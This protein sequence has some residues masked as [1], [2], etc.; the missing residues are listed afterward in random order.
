MKT[1]KIMAAPVLIICASVALSGCGGEDK[2]AKAKP[3]SSPSASATVNDG[4]DSQWATPKQTPSPQTGSESAGPPVTSVPSKGSFGNNPQAPDEDPAP[5]KTL[6]GG[7]QAQAEAKKEAVT[8]MGL[9][10]R[11]DESASGWR[12]DIRSRLTVQANRDFQDF[13]PSYL[14][15]T[16]VKKDSARVDG[17]SNAQRMTVVVTATPKDQDF[18]V[19]MVHMPDGSWRADGIEPA[20]L[21]QH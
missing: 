19:A 8:V 11:P 14:E 7:E 16:G 18:K 20:T 15:V 10:A 5:T 12:K 2:E 3:S 13:D 21:G 1:S 9:Y 17:E 6:S 4:N